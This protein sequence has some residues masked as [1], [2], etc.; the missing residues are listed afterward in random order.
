MGG[1]KKMKEKLDFNAEENLS[2]CTLNIL[3]K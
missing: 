2:R 1:E 3:P